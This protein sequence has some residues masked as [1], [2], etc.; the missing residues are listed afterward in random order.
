MRRQVVFL[1]T[2]FLLLAGCHRADTPPTSPPET[3]TPSPTVTPVPE[4]PVAYATITPEWCDT[5]DPAL[6]PGTGEATLQ[7]EDGTQIFHLANTDGEDI[8]LYGVWFSTRNFPELLI[9][10]G[11]NL[12]G[13]GTLLSPSASVS[14][15][16]WTDVDDD[17]QPELCAIF[18]QDAA[19]T[20]LTVYE[21]AEPTWT[22]HPYAEADYSAQLLALLDIQ[23][24][25]QGLT[26]SYGG[27]TADFFLGHNE[28]GPA[29][30][31]EDLSD[32]VIFRME[33]DSIY[34]VFGLGADIADETRYFGTMT[35][36]VEYGEE[37]F[38][39]YDLRLLSN[40]GV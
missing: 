17:G 28:S 40:S 8:S 12:Q 1:F 35:A 20:A 19:Q 32:F 18:H 33:Q 15:L 30:F 6:L 16:D 10:Y 38:G 2:L 31:H 23:P 14:T 36:R 21:W 11:E 4:T 25:P 29:A 13:A 7:Q 37:G 39:L 26:V 24:T 5:L 9:R 27:T 22:A 3:V 34:V